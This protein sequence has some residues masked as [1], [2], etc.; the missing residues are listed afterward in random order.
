MSLDGE[1]D[2]E[3]VAVPEADDEDQE[4]FADLITPRG[5]AISV[6]VYPVIAVPDDSGTSFTAYTLDNLRRYKKLSG[7]TQS[8]YFN[9]STSATTT[10]VNQIADAMQTYANQTG[11]DC[12]FIGWL[13]SCKF[14]QK[15]TRPQ[16]ITMKPT[17]STLEGTDEVTQTIP[18]NYTTSEFTISN[19]FTPYLELDQRQQFGY[20]GA[21]YY[22]TETGNTVGIML[23]S[24]FGIN[25]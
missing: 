1:E 19:V 9:L 4:T 14:Q 8:E 22:K 11:K 16:Y 12:V 24:G 25:Y 6:E 5:F 7:T 2:T 17:S 3:V 20:K 15:A 18:P 21:F 23:A 10:Y 13:V